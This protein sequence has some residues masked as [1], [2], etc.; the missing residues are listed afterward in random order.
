MIISSYLSSARAHTTTHTRAH[1]HSALPL[2]N[3][4]YIPALSLCAQPGWEVMEEWWGCVFKGRLETKVPP[5]AG[6]LLHHLHHPLTLPLPGGS[7]SPGL[8]CSTFPTL[9][10]GL[11]CI[12]CCPSERLFSGELLSIEGPS[13]TVCV[14]IS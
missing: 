11:I 2:L 1:T 14:F 8:A 4:P 12:P 9:T 10:S 13:L 5:E 6:L 7:P 3:K